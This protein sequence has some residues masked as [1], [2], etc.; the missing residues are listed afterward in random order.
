MALV[1]TR[2]K[3]ESIIIDDD[4]EVT[5]VGINGKQVKIAIKAPSEVNIVRAEL[6]GRGTSHDTE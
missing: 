6:L 3:G 2:R 1:L 4:I 5:V